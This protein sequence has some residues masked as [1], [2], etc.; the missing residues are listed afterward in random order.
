MEFSAR[1]LQSSRR[2]GMSL[3]EV[4]FGIGMM[5]LVFWSLFGVFK[6]SIEIVMSS[7]AKIGAL[8][9]ANEKVEFIRS[10]SY[11]AVGTAGG[12]PSGALPQTEAVSLNQVDYTRRTFIQYV[13]APQDGSGASDT[14][15][16][17]ADYKVVKVELTWDI[18]GD[19][20]SYSLVTSVVPRGMES[21]AGG[22][23]ISV[24]VLDAL[25]AP[26]PGAEVR[27]VNATTNPAIDVT[28][29]SNADGLVIFPGAPAASNYA[30][31]VTKD[32]YSTAQTYDS[33]AANPNPMPAHLSVAEAQTTNATFA[34]DRLSD[35]TVLTYEPIKTESFEDLFTS[36]ASVASYASTTLSGED[37]VLTQSLGMYDA[38]GSLTSVTIAPT[39]LYRWGSVAWEAVSPAG[40]SIR[41]QVLYESAPDSF[42]PLPDAVLPGNAAGFATSPVDISGVPVTY[43][44]LRLMASLTTND[45]LI[46]PTLA[47]WTLSYERGPVPVPSV[48]FAL[49]GTKTIGSD[50]GANPIY[51]Y[52]D[53]HTTD[54]GGQVSIDDLEWDTYLLTLGSGTGWDIAESCPFQPFGLSPG[55]TA[56]TTLYL[57]PESAHSLLLAVHDTAGAVIPG[58][59]VRLYRTGYDETQTGSSCGQTFFSD[60][61]AASYTAEVSA[62][63]FQPA[64]VSGIDVTGAASVLVQ[65]ESL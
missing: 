61:Q 44:R 31:T 9:L 65:L 62:P 29:F 49:R 12:I 57:V 45:G 59:V 8:A 19:T 7:K 4:V 64:T 32:G 18:K 2:K 21:L 60:L 43:P 6:I 42:T 13:D 37:V 56:T 50:A 48:P 33:T 5:A 20:R 39:L 35:L 16:I 24:A 10:L 52:D 51:K 46:T 23:T 28:T 53:D 17:T 54:S 15:A 38:L 30:V 25:G 40:T 58:G 14:N 63:G 26:L 55:V 3:I 11:D 34:I 27:V 41:T 47:S 1:H 36:G 22:G